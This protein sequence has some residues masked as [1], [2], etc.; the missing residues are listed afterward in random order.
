MTTPADSF[1]VPGAVRSAAARLSCPGTRALSMRVA[2][3]FEA[4][5]T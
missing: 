4:Q 3:R 5:A 1:Q 2:R